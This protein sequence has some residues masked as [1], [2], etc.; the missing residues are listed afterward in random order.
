M[1]CGSGRHEGTGNLVWRLRRASR[2]EE[3]HHIHH[4]L[5]SWSVVAPFLLVLLEE[6]VRYP[7]LRFGKMLEAS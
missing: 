7:P 2:Q 3:A 1:E 6:L 4:P 5:E